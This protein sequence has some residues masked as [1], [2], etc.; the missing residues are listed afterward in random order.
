MRI[1]AGSIGG[2]VVGGVLGLLAATQPASTRQANRQNGKRQ[3]I[4]EVLIEEVM[5]T[6]LESCGGPSQGRRRV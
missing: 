2:I 1:L 6:T 3:R 4:E 5:G